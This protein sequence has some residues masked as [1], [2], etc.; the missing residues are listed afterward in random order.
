MEKI[1][2]PITGKNN[3]TVIKKIPVRDITNLYNSDF[4]FS[5][6]RFFNDLEYIILLECQDSK[7]KFYYPFTIFGDSKFYEDLQK[8]NESKSGDDNYYVEWKWEYSEA[9]KWINKTHSVLD[10]GCG[11]GKFLDKVKREFANKVRG[12]EF[13]SNALMECR[14]KGLEVYP[15]SIEEYSKSGEKF[16][17]ITYFQVL[18]HI[19][20]PIDFI[21]SSLNALKQGGKLII[22]V[23]NN[24]PYYLCFEEASTLNLPP[25]HAGLWGKESLTNLPNFL[26]LKL[27]Q[28][29]ESEIAPMFKYLYY[30]SRGMFSRIFGYKPRPW[31]FFLFPLI[32]LPV[33]IPII[34]YKKF[35][36]QLIGRTI[37]AVYE[38]T[39]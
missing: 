31:W 21:Q 10:I 7:Y 34:L 3:T 9:L 13:N 1:L 19:N 32:I 23:P 6:D 14:K 8:S 20:Y 11:S 27:I 22:G 37:V 16:D 15:I 17:I 26:P 29:S 38:K 39:I 28:V 36:N 18:E 33:S 12:I 30:F 24:K 25:H 35:T 4:G 5:V 2:S